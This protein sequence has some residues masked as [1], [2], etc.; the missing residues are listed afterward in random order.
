MGDVCWF[1]GKCVGISR[2]SKELL[3]S[4]R[5]PPPFFFLLLLGVVSGG[6]G[7]FICFSADC[8]YFFS[9]VFLQACSLV[10]FSKTWVMHDII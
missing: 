3:F 9:S 2:P 10:F 5:I 6:G 8:S 7:C 4:G 1:C